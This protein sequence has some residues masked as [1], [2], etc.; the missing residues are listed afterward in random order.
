VY[1]SS[2]KPSS[3]P[4][5]ITSTVTP[6]KVTGKITFLTGKCGTVKFVAKLQG[7]RP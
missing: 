6:S 7:S 2:N 5:K 1:G 3:D 4:V